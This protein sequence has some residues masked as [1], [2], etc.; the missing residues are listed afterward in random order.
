[1]YN[2]LKNLEIQYSLIESFEL[3]FPFSNPIRM[4]N[5]VVGGDE[6]GWETCTKCKLQPDTC[7]LLARKRSRDAWNSCRA[8]QYHRY[9]CDTMRRLIFVIVSCRNALYRISIGNIVFFLPTGWFDQSPWLL[10][11]NQEEIQK[12]T[13]IYIAG[14]RARK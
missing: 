3:R 4:M 13:W 14:W 9:D 10:K 12:K 11:W 1:M 2:I 5:M 6:E 7:A 8:K